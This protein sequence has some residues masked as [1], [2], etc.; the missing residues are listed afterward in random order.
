MSSNWLGYGGASSAGAGKNTAIRL[1]STYEF[2]DVNSLR[3]YSMGDFITT[4]LAWTRPVHMEGAQIRSD[5]SM[6]PDLVTFPMPSIKR[7]GG[8]AF[9]GAGAHKRQ[10]P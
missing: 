2:A 10:H 6:R 1:D 8:G 7:L 3:R 4:G 5:F 9:D